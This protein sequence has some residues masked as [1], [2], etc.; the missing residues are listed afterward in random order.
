MADRDGRVPGLPLLHQEEGHRRP[1]EIGAADDD[2]AASFDRDL[3]AQKQLQATQ[4]RAGNEFR[5]AGGQPSKVEGMNAVDVLAGIHARDNFGLVQM[6][7]QRQLAKDSIDGQIAVELIDEEKNFLARDIGGKLMGHGMKTRL[8]GGSA[9]VAHINPARR[10]LPDDD[11]GQARM[12]A[13]VGATPLDP[14]GYLPADRQGGGFSIQDFG[15]HWM[16]ASSRARADCFAFSPKSRG[17]PTQE[18]HPPE[19]PQ[20]WTSFNAARMICRSIPKARRARPIPPGTR[21]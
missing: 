15:R 4:R 19:Q 14:L 5:I 16:I 7:R 13:A 3:V 8:L 10:I 17:G 12:A 11:G 1:H 18:G 6:R 9:F 2:G 20:P 21:S